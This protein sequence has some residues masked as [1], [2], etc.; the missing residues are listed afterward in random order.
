M[1][2]IIPILLI[3]SF[4]GIISCSKE[5]TKS[6]KFKLLTTPTW[7]SDS[8]LVNGLDASGA[9]GLLENF[10]GDVK[11]NADY[12]GTF[13]QYV[14]TWR[15]AF[16]ETEVVIASDSLALP[17]TA[18]I[19]VLTQTDLKIKTSYQIP[20]TGSINIRMTFKVK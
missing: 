12:S 6:E 16:N 14:G 5:N 1:K 7:Q 3:C 13:G 20:G 19:D 11:F 9:G 4:I 17:I 10:K 8:L 18:V 2:N 15:F